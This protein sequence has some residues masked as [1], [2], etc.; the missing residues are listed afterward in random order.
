LEP[1]NFANV[2]ADVYLDP[3][4][5]QNYGKIDCC[6]GMSLDQIDIQ[7]TRI[8]FDVP[9]HHLVEAAAISQK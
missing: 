6:L 4:K 2:T 9:T 8:C 5:R 7:M 1:L 3:Y